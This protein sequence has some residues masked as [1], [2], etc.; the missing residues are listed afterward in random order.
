MDNYWEK[1]Y[2]K[3]DHCTFFEWYFD[4]HTISPL[5]TEQLELANEESQALVIGSGTSQLGDHLYDNSKFKNITCIDI[6]EFVINQMTEFYVSNVV[7]RPGLKFQ[8]MDAVIMSD[9]EDAA[10]D[11]VFDK[12][13]FDSLMCEETGMID[14][15]H[16]I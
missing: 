15:F 8:V 9:F 1:R 6:S 12:G 11:I 13:T 5:I 2:K 10:F 14:N 7:R 16:M 3:H 4:Y